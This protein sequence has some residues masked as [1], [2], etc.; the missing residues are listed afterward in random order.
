MHERELQDATEPTLDRAIG[1]ARVVV[2][3]NSKMCLAAP[4]SG[5]RLGLWPR[6]TVLAINRVV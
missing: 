1:V 6:W 2:T 3:Q 4:A 5:E